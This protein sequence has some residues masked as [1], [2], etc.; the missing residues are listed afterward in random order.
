MMNPTHPNCPNLNTTQI[1]S[2]QSKV[3]VQKPELK[4]SSSTNVS[5]VNTQTENIAKKSKHCQ[6]TPQ[7]QVNKSSQTVE[8]VP[9]LQKQSKRIKYL[10]KRVEWLQKKITRKDR[11]LKKRIRAI[12]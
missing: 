3:L 11:K 2:T 8:S 5:S 10:K 7:T 12:M 6:T 9:K 1:S 4:G